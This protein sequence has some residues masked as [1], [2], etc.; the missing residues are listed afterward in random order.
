MQ[1]ARDC[2]SKCSTKSFDKRVNHIT[3][4]SPQSG[5]RWGFLPSGNITFNIYKPLNRIN[6][7]GHWWALLP[8]SSTRPPG[9]V[10]VD[11][12]DLGNVEG[13]QSRCFGMR[14]LLKPGYI[15]KGR[16]PEAKLGQHF[17]QTLQC[18]CEP[19]LKLQPP[20]LFQEPRRSVS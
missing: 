12:M 9:F 19:F 7:G 2:F 10:T 18:Y 17:A 14:P 16:G 13:F 20:H 3:G 5:H 15:E 11:L 8:I 4:L 6:H 1:T